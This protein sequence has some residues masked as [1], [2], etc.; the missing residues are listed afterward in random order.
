MDTDSPRD[1]SLDGLIDGAI[2]ISC[3][4]LRWWREYITIIWRWPTSLR[5]G[6]VL[7]V[8]LF[9]VVMTILLLCIHR[10]S[11]FSTVELELPDI[12]PIKPSEHFLFHVLSKS[13][14]KTCNQCATGYACIECL[15]SAC[16]CK[17]MYVR[18]SMNR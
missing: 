13:K 18:A 11:S 6:I 12:H 3:G 5:R 8:W 4:M 2:R 9:M 17:D 1:S 7:G 10:F 15:K 16:E 14:N